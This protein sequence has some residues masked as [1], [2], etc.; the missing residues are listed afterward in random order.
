MR[1]LRIIR[2]EEKAN[3]LPLK[4]L[5]PLA[6]FLFPISI[7]IVLTPITLKVLKLITEMGPR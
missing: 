6:T 7:L 2:A 1:E 3:T 4:M 5:F